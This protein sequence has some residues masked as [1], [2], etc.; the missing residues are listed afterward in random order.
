[1]RKLV[2][3]VVTLLFALVLL[4]YL[5]GAQFVQAVIGLLGA[6]A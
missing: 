4:D 3:Y 1:M 5:T 2:A 6:V